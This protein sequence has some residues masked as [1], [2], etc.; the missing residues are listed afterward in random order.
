MEVLQV[1]PKDWYVRIELSLTQVDQ[2]LDFLDNCEC[3]ID[4]KDE[5]LNKAKE[6]VIKEFFPK[7][8]TLV[9][10]MKKGEI[11]GS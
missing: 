8:N 3:A 10:E 1:Y 5:R 11:N 2:L 4:P 7:M 6:Y 9:D